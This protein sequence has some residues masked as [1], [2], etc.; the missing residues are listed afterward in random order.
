MG[1]QTERG[2]LVPGPIVDEEVKETPEM[3]PA[4]WILWILEGVLIFHYCTK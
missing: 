2:L 4:V 3:L 1:L